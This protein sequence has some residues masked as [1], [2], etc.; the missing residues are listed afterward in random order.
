ML[1]FYSSVRQKGVKMEE[2][3]NF[4]IKLSD[5][6]R[7][8]Q[9]EAKMREYETRATGKG[10]SID[11]PGAFDYKVR[12]ALI[13]TLVE[14]GEVSIIDF[15]LEL[16]ATSEYFDDRVFD[17]SCNVIRDYVE[18]GGMNCSGGTGLPSV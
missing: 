10:L 8:K 11:D 14:R 17:E 18:T 16:R 15:Y 7:K 1:W 13:A 5:P 2:T 3:V 12:N 9:L 4:K 6:E